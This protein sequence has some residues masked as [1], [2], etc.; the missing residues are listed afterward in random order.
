MENDNRALRLAFCQVELALHRLVFG[1][2]SSVQRW[3]SYRQEHKKLKK[4]NIKSDLMYYPLDEPA[5][6]L[7]QRL[8]KHLRDEPAARGALEQAAIQA[9]SVFDGNLA[10]P[11]GLRVA[12]LLA[13]LDADAVS[14]I[15]AVLADQRLDLPDA[16][17]QTLL[18]GVT[19]EQRCKIKAQLEAILKVRQLLVRYRPDVSSKQAIM[20]QRL[21]FAI[22]RDVRVVLVLL[23]FAVEQMRGLV[24]QS[25]L[26]Q[27]RKAAHCAMHVF[28]PMAHQLGLGQIKWELEDLAFRHLQPEVYADIARKLDDRR[29]NRERYLEKIREA[30]AD[31]LAKAGITA[32]VYG[33]PKHIYSIWSKMQKKRLSFEQLFDVHALRIEVE[34]VSACYAA[35]SVVHDL[36]TPIERE[37]DDYIA[38]P[39]PNGYQ[40]LHTAVQAWE[41]KVVE[42]QIRTH[43]MHAFAEFGVAAHWRYKSGQAGYH[44]MQESIESIRREWDKADQIGGKPG[45]QTIATELDVSHVYVFTPD[46]DLL[47]LPAQATV[48]D[49]AY[50]IHTQIGH[51]CR[52]ALINGNIA[53]LKS[54]LQQG[55]QVR[56]LTQKNAQPS[57]V[58]GRAQSGFLHSASARAKVRNYFA[59]QDHH[60]RRERGRL[61]TERLLRHLKVN[62]SRRETLVRQLG[63]ADENQL[64]EAVGSGKM[65]L[66]TITVAARK[67]QS[68]E[69]PAGQH[70]DQQPAEPTEDVAIEQAS[71]CIESRQIDGL[72]AT[73]ARCCNPKP[74]EPVMAFLSQSQGYKLHRPDCPNL[75][76]LVR[77]YPERILAVQWPKA[78]PKKN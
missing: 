33:R 71:L 42:I 19:S 53:P 60:N 64:F 13:E 48:L 16:I 58:W 3:E 66:E 36:F 49:F 61:L 20:W 77:Q 51:R 74:G 40:S 76:H 29:V 67:Q 5:D 56:V 10:I 46:G 69:K 68:N 65:A 31:A 59:R 44:P 62:A 15:V 47:E 9:D 72:K 38:R 30:L 28:A 78:D 45:E 52:G 26:Q 57:R 4:L 23:A 18:G 11:R 14:L 39:K 21:I 25:D 54:R 73:I 1:C 37:Y 12:C 27:C 63:F 43:R 6:I 7:I 75:N 24:Y 34:T 35:L 22:C 41:G 70:V 2:L 17:M 32:H 50:K 8:L 55:D